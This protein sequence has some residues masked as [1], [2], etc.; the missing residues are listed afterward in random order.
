MNRATVERH[1]ATF[2][3]PIGVLTLEADDIGLSHLWLPTKSPA[4]TAVLAPGNDVLEETIRQLNAY[5]EGDLISFDLPLSPQGTAFQLA[6]W[7]T[8]ST[9]P[10]AT[11]TSYVDIA[12][13]AGRPRAYR[14]VGQAN[15]ANPIAIIVPCHRVIAASGGIGGYGGGIAAKRTLLDLEAKHAGLASPRFVGDKG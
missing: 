1:V 12:L 8:L 15:G 3:S 10:Y 5:F 9:I 4:P 13:R 7:E 11:T 2:T 14:A 6:V